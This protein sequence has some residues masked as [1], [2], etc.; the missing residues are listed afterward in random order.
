MAWPLPDSYDSIVV[1]CCE[2]QNP[3][4]ILSGKNIQNQRRSFKISGVSYLIIGGSEPFDRKIVGRCQ[5]P[6]NGTLP[7]YKCRL[8]GRDNQ[9]L[10]IVMESFELYVLRGCYKIFLVPLWLILS[11]PVSHLSLPIIFSK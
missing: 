1:T 2:V 6:T 3:R 9:T 7:F 8:G 5:G 10:A 11:L 4:P